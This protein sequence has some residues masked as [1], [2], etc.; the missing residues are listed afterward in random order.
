MKNG[1]LNV[2][3]TAG[4]LITFT[5]C[6]KDPLIPPPPPPSDG[7]IETLNGGTGGSNAVNSVFVDF[8]RN[9]QD[10]VKR[11]GWDLGFYCS[12][13][14][15][16]VKIN[17]TTAASAK[18]TTKNDITQITTAD[19]AGFG[20]ALLLG[21]G[22]GNMQIVDDVEGDL[23][24]TAI[25]PV[26][27]IDAD[28]KVYILS[29][30]NGFVAAAK[31]WYKIRITRNP[32]GYRVQYA[33]LS[34]TTIK[35]IDVPKDA[36]YNFKYVSLATNAIVPAE[37]EKAGW[38]LQWTLTTYKASPDLPF[39][40]ADFV[41]INYLAGVQAAEVMN[42]TVTYANYTEANVA[43][44]TFTNA[45]TVIGSKWRITAP[46]NGPAVRTDRFYVI[47]DEPG[48]VY[49]VKFVSFSTQDG[50]VRGK[51]VIEYKLVKKA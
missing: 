26:S 5:S 14:D 12:S 3:L 39:T 9:N 4:F 18:A 47:K 21:N 41:Y 13:S 38:D 20:E 46:P 36:D 25:A 22:F 43:T 8:S 19:T 40:F 42:T 30:S 37:P 10:S 7:K 6:K 32:A 23:T 24:K 35:I 31:D 27:A 50:G 51:P 15:F 34:E 48:N 1:F 45:K 16:R 17:N 49:K 2:A 29:P 44:T 28:N 33:K 11:T